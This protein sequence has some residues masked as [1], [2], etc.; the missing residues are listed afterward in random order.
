LKMKII[1]SWKLIFSLSDC[2]VHGMQLP[3]K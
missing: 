2:I 1:R 3:S